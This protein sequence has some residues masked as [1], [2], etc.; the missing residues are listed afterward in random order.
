MTP[1]HPQTRLAIALPF[2]GGF[3]PAGPAFGIVPGAPGGAPGGTTCGDWVSCS[4]TAPAPASPVW[5]E[6]KSRTSLAEIQFPIPSHHT[7]SDPATSPD[8][9]ILLS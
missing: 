3:T 2:A 7:R 8:T 4:G 5:G 6:S 9:T 1:T